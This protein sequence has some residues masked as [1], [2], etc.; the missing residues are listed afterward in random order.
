MPRDCPLSTVPGP[1][2]ETFVGDDVNTLVIMNLLS[3]TEYSIKVIATY[4]TGAS[5]ALTGKAKTRKAGNIPTAIC[6]AYVSIHT[7][8]HL[9]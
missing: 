1:A 5:I 6:K 2:L 3:D 9:A 4:S 7:F 8:L